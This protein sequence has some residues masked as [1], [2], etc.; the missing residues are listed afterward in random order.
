MS[1]LRENYQVIYQLVSK[2]KI[3]CSGEALGT[4]DRKIVNYLE[5]KRREIT[6]LQLFEQMEMRAEKVKAVKLKMEQSQEH[7]G[8]QLFQTLRKIALVQSDIQ[9]KVKKEIDWMKKLLLGSREGFYKHLS[10]L[11]HLPKH[12]LQL[13]RELARRNAYNQF[14]STELLN[15]FSRLESA[16][17]EEILRREEF[18]KLHGSNLPPI[19]FKSFPSLKEKPPL[20]QQNFQSMVEAVPDIPMKDS[21]IQSLFAK[22]R[23]DSGQV[24]NYANSSVQAEAEVE[25]LTPKYQELL[26]SY[27]KLKKETQR[28]DDLVKQMEEQVAD[29]P[30]H[31]KEE[32]VPSSHAKD[33]DALFQDVAEILQFIATT[34]S[35]DASFAN[36]FND[37]LHK[38]NPQD[39]FQLRIFQSNR[40]VKS[41]D[42]HIS[43]GKL[44]KDM[45]SSFKQ[46]THNFS[47]KIRYPV[48]SFMDFQAGDI[49]LFMPAYVNNR[50][51]WM[52]F[53]SG[54]PYRFLAE[55]R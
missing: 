43:L 51:I 40:T 17:D 37:P 53:N 45:I 28:L 18:M 16:R 8:K 23:S 6:E 31:S 2:L 34:I 36:Y 42:S 15:T 5:S 10:Q 11:Y 13:E 27:D 14:V 12:Y 54:Y 46:L 33:E 22:Y 7:L 55:V 1:K 4:E 19:F 39:D 50:K 3:E 9:Y 26:E 20:M 21:S 29:S 35:E 48:I 30:V 38:S 41:G 24:V 49:A 25:D 47:R 32:A 44:S 52:A